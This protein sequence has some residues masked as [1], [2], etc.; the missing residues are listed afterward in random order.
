M[1]ILEF[2]MLSIMNSNKVSIKKFSQKML[3]NVTKG[4]ITGGMVEYEN[5]EKKTTQKTS[6]LEKKVEELTTKGDQQK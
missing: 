3:N 6:E 1:K 2:N 5:R 4:N